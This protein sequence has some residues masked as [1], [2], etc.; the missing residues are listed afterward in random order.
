[1]GLLTPHHL[2]STQVLIVQSL[3][4]VVTL[5]Q[6]RKTIDDDSQ[7][8]MAFSF[9]LPPQSQL[10]PTPL[11][12]VA[13]LPLTDVGSRQKVDPILKDWFNKV[14]APPVGGVYF[15]ITKS[16]LLRHY[17]RAGSDTINTTIAVPESLRQLVLQ[18]AHD[19]CL[20]GHSGFKKTLSN[21]QA[22]FSWPGLSNDVCCYTR[23][24]HVCQVRSR[25]RS[26]RPAPF[27]PVMPMEIPFQRVIIDIVGPLP[28]S[29][30][31]HEYILT[32][33]DLSTRWAEGVPLRHI[34]AKDVAQSLFNLFCRLEFLCEI[35]SDKGQQFMSQIL[36]EFNSLTNMKNFLSSPYHPQTFILL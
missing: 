23:S 17:Q 9:D 36:R 29:Q 35:H 8:T 13:G 10:I 1:M 14:N 24:C 15:A 11:N 6:T 2:T 28:V 12:C 25:V 19:N 18:Y 16:K 3:Q 5:A 30:N 4:R 32:L 31:R 26:D 20:S 34:L 33:V 21:I 22:Y 27:Q 7:N